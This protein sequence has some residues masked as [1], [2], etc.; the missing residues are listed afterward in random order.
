[1]TSNQ[2]DQMNLNAQQTPNDTRNEF[3]EIK[4]TRARS[5]AI[6]QMDKHINVSRFSTFLLPDRFDMTKT[7]G[8]YFN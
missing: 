8:K 2:M 7:N 5:M 3:N 1:M 6:T 4:T